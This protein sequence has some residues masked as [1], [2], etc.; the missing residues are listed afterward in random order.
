MYI[1]LT[2][3][4][5]HY[6]YSMK[7]FLRWVLSLL[8]HQTKLVVSFLVITLQFKAIFFLT[9]R[10]CSL[11]LSLS[12][13]LNLSLSLI[14]WWLAFNYDSNRSHKA[15]VILKIETKT[16]DYVQKNKGICINTYLRKTEYVLFSGNT[17]HSF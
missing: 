15:V 5:L 2:R 14:S 6:Y 13:S 3:S 1:V 4:V 10:N 12:L 17:N 7:I 11:S 8:L 9:S 16:R